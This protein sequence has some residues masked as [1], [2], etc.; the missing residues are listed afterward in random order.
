MLGLISLTT[1]VSVLK[2]VYY[3]IEIFIF[4][5]KFTNKLYLIYYLIKF[6]IIYKYNLM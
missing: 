6:T 3:C 1:G 5:L 2:L 4:N